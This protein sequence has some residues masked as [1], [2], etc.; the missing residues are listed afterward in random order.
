MQY[1]RPAVERRE[2]V[3]G[4]MTVGSGVTSSSIK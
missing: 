3:K 1:E 4:L 2:S